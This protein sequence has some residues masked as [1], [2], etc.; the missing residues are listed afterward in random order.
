MNVKSLFFRTR[1]IR[2]RRCCGSI[3]EEAPA[4]PNLFCSPQGAHTAFDH[5]LVLG[6]IAGT[7]DPAA[8]IR[9]LAEAG[10]DGILMNLGMVSAVADSMLVERP[11]A[12]IVRL[13]WTSLWTADKSNGKLR[14]R[15]L[16]TVEQALRAGADAVLTYLFVGTGDAEF[17]SDEVARNAAVARECESL[18]VP[19]IVE[20]L[21][22]GPRAHDPLAVEW[23]N[24]HTRIAAELGADVIKTEYTGDPESM[25]EVVK[26]CP[27][28]IL[29]LGGAR[30]GSDEEELDIVAGAMAAGAAGIF[31]G[32][33]IFQSG[34]LCN[35]VQ[36][37]RGIL[38]GA[39]SLDGVAAPAND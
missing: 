16:G 18:G 32:R 5:A 1:S 38:N 31:F 36:R 15:L 4:E 17:E 37:A 19:M 26:T 27:V 13:D 30:Q 8:Q 7:V 39:A 14:S 21:A 34:N 24:L 12:L 10:V 22:R 2:E 3:R 25:A 29:V 35:F 9:R 6:P 20:S 33:N 11:P 23:M 28:P